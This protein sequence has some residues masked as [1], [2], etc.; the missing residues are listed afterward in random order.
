MKPKLFFAAICFFT[1]NLFSQVVYEKGY[2]IQNNDSKTECFIKNTDSEK[3]LISF[4]YKKN[5]NG[6]VEL[7]TMDKIKEFG[8]YSRFKYIR[9]TVKIDKSSLNVNEMNY[10][11][12]PEFI[13]KT[14]FLKVLI[15]GKA[16]LYSV[17]DEYGMHYFYSKDTMGIKPL[18]Y[19][20]FLKKNNSIG[21]NSDYKNQLWEE[22]KIQNS[23]VKQ[24]KN[25]AYRKNDLIKYF[26][27]YNNSVN[28]EYENFENA[29]VA[30]GK[31]HIKANAGIDFTSI[32][33][34]GFGGINFGDKITSTIGAELE[35]IMPFNNNKWAIFINPLYKHYKSESEF[36]ATSSIIGNANVN[37][38][39]I[40][41]PLGV[42][43]YF[44]LNENSKFFINAGYTVEILLND[45]IVGDYNFNG[46][47]KLEA[48]NGFSI[49]AGYQYT[50]YSIE[51]RYNLKQSLST[52]LDG[53]DHNMTSILLGYK[54]L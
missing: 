42:R 27:W 31:F 38:S 1:T 33:Y 9:H 13:E 5:E 19:K 29:T 34:T 44:Y 37:Y 2:F 10:G 46:G 47:K 7:G 8:I 16:S 21:T 23:D 36:R 14:T 50:N 28:S 45:K 52:W 6:E 43:H 32:N 18:I 39:A 11:R 15:T 24:F 40:Q 35:Y 51:L 12:E 20:Q 4:Y 30:K 41:I 48:G 17:T 26:E 25:L 53:I 54:I 3:N 22:L 49:G